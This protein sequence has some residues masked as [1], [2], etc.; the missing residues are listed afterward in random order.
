L[1]A[2]VSAGSDYRR[3]AASVILAIPAGKLVHTILDNYAK[4]PIKPIKPIK[5]V[6]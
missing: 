4:G 2:C 1:E 6:W 3:G 5:K